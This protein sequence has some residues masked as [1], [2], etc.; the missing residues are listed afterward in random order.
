M[1]TTHVVRYE[2]GPLDDTTQNHPAE[3]P[4]FIDVPEQR[5]KPGPFGPVIDQLTH[6]YARASYTVEDDGASVV[7]T[8]RLVGHP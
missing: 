2:G 4:Q 6:R 5:S 1:I 7:Y 3:P 8:Y